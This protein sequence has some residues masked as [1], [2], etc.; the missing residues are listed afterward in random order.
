M[1][2]N[3]TVCIP[4]YNSVDYIED[5]IRLPLFDNRVDEIIIND[6]ASDENEYEKLV[7]KVNS[8]LNGE[9]ISYDVN[10]RLISEQNANA[11]PSVFYMTSQDVSEQSKKIVVYRN[12]KNIGGFANKYETIKKSTNEWVYL[13]DSDN[14]LVDCSIPSLYNIDEWD[15]KICYCP[16]TP[17]MERKDG[18]RAWDDWN[19][20]RFGYEPIDL[21][22]IKLLF[23]V[24]DSFH[25][26]YNCGLGVNGFLNTGNFFV[27]RDYY[28]KVLEEP[29]RENIEPHAADVLAFSYYWLVTGNMFQIVPDLYYYHRLRKNSFWQR[30]GNQSGIEAQ[31]YEKMIRNA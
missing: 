22:R 27:N 14:F 1:K 29:I 26:Q 5:A 19:H 4:F 21:E 31:K 13:L 15:E 28:L 9:Q 2:S 3:I 24:D 23:E 18:W 7:S 16:S 6:D 25:S 12:R 20:R 8:L 17:I 11:L 10:Y 30:T